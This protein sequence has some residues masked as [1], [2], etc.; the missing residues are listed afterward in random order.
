M[1]KAYDRV[2]WNFLEALLSKMGFGE[3][4]I[5]RILCGVKIVSYRI[6]VNGNPQGSFGP[7]KGIRQGDSLSHYM[8]HCLII[9]SFV[10]LRS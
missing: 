9:C 6:L 8:F 2:D 4:S 5:G 7:Q 10:K 3:V 1:A